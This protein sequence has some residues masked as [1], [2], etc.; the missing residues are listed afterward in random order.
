MCF[1]CWE[2][3]ACLRIR[4]IKAGFRKERSEL[5][6]L[7]ERAKLGSSE[8]GGLE[9]LADVFGANMKDPISIPTKE[10]GW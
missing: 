3:M 6:E 5:K 10:C 7:Q 4:V 2:G 8:R 1:Q 9:A